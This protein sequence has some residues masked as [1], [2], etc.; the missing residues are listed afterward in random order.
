MRFISD[1]PLAGLRGG[2]GAMGLP[3]SS[4]IIV[5]SSSDEGSSSLSVSVNSPF[6]ISESVSDS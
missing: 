2:A 3:S 4:A 5:L 6:S 1:W